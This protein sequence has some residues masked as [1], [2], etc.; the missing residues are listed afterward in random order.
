MWPCLN[1]YVGGWI[2]LAQTPGNNSHHRIC[3]SQQELEIVFLAGSA[4]NR[5]SKVC[6]I[7]VIFI[8]SGKMHCKGKFMLVGNNRTD[9]IVLLFPIYENIG[10]YTVIMLGW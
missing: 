9:E 6:S 10:T 4:E 5:D 2:E 1:H 8:G 3:I 7:F